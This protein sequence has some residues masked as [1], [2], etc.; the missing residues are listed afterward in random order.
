VS[1]QS[2][3]RAPNQKGAGE[4]RDRGFQVF[5]EFEPLRGNFSGV[6]GPAPDLIEV[7]VGL[8]VATH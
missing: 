7:A 1:L 6:R 5:W 8:I 4:S 2:V 3:G